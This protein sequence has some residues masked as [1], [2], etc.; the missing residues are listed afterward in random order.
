LRDQGHKSAERYLEWLAKETRGHDQQAFGAFLAAHPEVGDVELE[1]VQARVRKLRMMT[2][3]NRYRAVEIGTGDLSEKA[4]GWSTYAGDHIAMYDV[5]CGIPKTLVEFVIRWVANER[6]QTWASSGG[7][8]LRAVLFDILEAPISPE[9]LP[10]SAEGRISQLTESAI[11][12]Y[13]LH[14]FFLYWFV[15]HGTRPARILFL[16]EHAFG[17]DYS[18]EELRKWL[19][20]FYRRFFNSQWKRDCTADGPKVGNVAL[21]P[22]GDWRMPSDAVVQSWL[23]EIERA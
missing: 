14:D 13:E 5:N 7:E 15:R 6:I 21:S 16:A 1:N 2:K 18:P 22:R 19:L 20:T 12:P 8:D 9:L 4:L 10:P 11:G 3:A 23:E 17:Q